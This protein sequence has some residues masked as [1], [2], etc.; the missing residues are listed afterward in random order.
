MGHEISPSGLIAVA[1]A[2][3]ATAAAKPEAEEPEIDALVRRAISTAY[4][5]LFHKVCGLVATKLVPRDMSGGRSILWARAYRTLDHQTALNTAKRVVK[6]TSR[7]TLGHKD[8]SPS[9]PAPDD[10]G[11]LHFCET[12]ILL[13][14]ARQSAD[15]NPDE[16]F[17]R[18]DAMV[19]IEQ[20]AQAIANWESPA[21]STQA[22][23]LVAELLARPPR[24]S[25]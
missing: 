20:A 10:E 7:P 22:D 16:W 2:L 15:Y 23:R 19:M 1:R 3:C 14:E 12:F 5:A 18:D 11:L 4:Y 13:F 21:M 17:S 9:Q 25:S 24:T 8:H 6:S